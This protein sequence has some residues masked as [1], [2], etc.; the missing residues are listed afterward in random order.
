MQIDITYHKPTIND[1]DILMEYV[2]EHYD[3]GEM[4]ISASL[5]LASSNYE[6]WLDKV[7]QM[8]VVSKDGW[9]RSNLYLVCYNDCLVGL[10]NVRYEMS[11]ELQ[12]IYGNIGY[13]VRPSARQ[14]GF[15][16]EMLRYALKECEVNGLKYA[17]VGCVEENIA[18]QKTMVRNGGQLIH[19]GVGYQKDAVNLYYKFTLQKPTPEPELWDLY[20]RDKKVS[21]KTH[22]RGVWP[23]PDGYYHMIVHAWIKN[24]KGEFLMSQRAATRPSHPLEWECV[25]GSVIKGETSLEAAIREIKEEVGLGLLPKDAKLVFTKI[26]DRIGDLECRDIMEVYLFEYD[27]EVDLNNSTTDEVTQIMWMTIDEIKA[28]YAK[29]QM[30]YTLD[31]FFKKMA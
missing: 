2:Q 24:S 8:A 26:R 1:K 18:S 31:Y 12:K 6:E 20:T 27:G 21:G 5:G 7:N 4:H 16:T 22:V 15:A 28:L 13:G 17:I 19:R 30:V 10:L 14:M 3:N 25:G 29:K 11:E 9:G 23:I